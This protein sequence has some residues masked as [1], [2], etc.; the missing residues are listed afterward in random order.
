[1]SLSLSKITATIS[2]AV[3]AEKAITGAAAI[4][5]TA[6]SGLVDAAETAYSGAVAA[7]STKKAAVLAGVEALATEVGADFATIKA[8]VSQLIDVSV[9]SYKALVSAA[10]AS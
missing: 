5:Y 8:D 2:A 1:M 6:V 3:A 7:G 10:S 4:V 9:S